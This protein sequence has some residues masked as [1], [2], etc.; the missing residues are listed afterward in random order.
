MLDMCVIGSTSHE[1]GQALH[2]HIIVAMSVS[3]R[4]EIE[5]TNRDV[6]KKIVEKRMVTTPFSQ[7]C[8]GG[9]Q[10]PFP[11]KDNI[12]YRNHVIS[13]I[14]ICIFITYIRSTMYTH[15]HICIY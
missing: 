11:E 3:L 2:S 14:H 10:D 8:E 1:V 9:H 4:N 7:K 12:R 6:N 5:V 15:D 13:N